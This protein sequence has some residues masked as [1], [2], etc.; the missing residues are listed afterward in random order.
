MIGRP[1][2]THHKE[3]RHGNNTDR[4]FNP[5][6]YRRTAHLASQQKLGIL[7]QRRTRI[8]PSDSDH[9]VAPWED[10]KRV[11]EIIFDAEQAKMG[12]ELVYAVDPISPCFGCC[13]G[14]PMGD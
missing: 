12:K 10:L 14:D 9:P 3:E 4:H 6:A 2:F 13:W 1:A 7:S 5:H 8:D 11:R